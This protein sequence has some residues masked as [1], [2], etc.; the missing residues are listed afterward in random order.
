MMEKQ[1]KQTAPVI[2]NSE[3]RSSLLRRVEQVVSAVATLAV[4]IVVLYAIYHILVLGNYPDDSMMEVLVILSLATLL[5]LLSSA[6]WQAYNI[7]RFRGR[8]RRKAVPM[9]SDT[10]LAKSFAMSLPT[11]RAVQS[12]AFVEVSS[13]DDQGYCV[14]KYP[15]Q[16]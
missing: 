1:M 10:E 15:S 6:F 14:K 2:D 13:L 16:D 11:Y 9:P 5:L 4:W 8:E 7:H 3:K 12:S